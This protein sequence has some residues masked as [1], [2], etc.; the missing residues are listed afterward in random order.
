[1]NA[2]VVIERSRD[3]EVVDVG[4]RNH[5]PLPSDGSLKLNE[6]T[7]ATRREKFYQGIQNAEIHRGVRSPA[8][9]N[10]RLRLAAQEH[11]NRTISEREALLS[12]VCSFEPVN[13]RGRK[14]LYIVVQGK[15]LQGVGEGKT[16]IQIFEHLRKML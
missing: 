3:D 11:C 12:G 9:G 8:G 7:V 1:V 2:L 13:R 16:E 15:G 14:V 4:L 5:V 6:A 10:G